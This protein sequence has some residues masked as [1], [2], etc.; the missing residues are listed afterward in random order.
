MTEG[1]K[2]VGVRIRG[3][4]ED[5]MLLQEG[6]TSQGMQ[7]VHR[8]WKGKEWIISQSF[9]KEADLSTP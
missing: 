8:E 7:V 2:K 6:A 9:Q 5:V 4:L 1:G 3:R